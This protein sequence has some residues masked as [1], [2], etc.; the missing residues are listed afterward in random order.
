[1]AKVKTIELLRICIKCERSS[2][3][4]VQLCKMLFA[5]Y[6]FFKKIY[7]FKW[8]FLKK[9][10]NKI[11]M[12]PNTNELIMYIYLPC[13]T[14]VQSFI[15]NLNIRKSF[16]VYKIPLKLRF[17]TEQIGRIWPKYNMHISIL[18]TTIVDLYW[19]PN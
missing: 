17:T 7:R 13:T 12:V 3:Y 5:C 8:D 16:C 15:T 14:T 18:F 4:N 1:M 11:E 19:I 2:T 9:K 6:L 10:N